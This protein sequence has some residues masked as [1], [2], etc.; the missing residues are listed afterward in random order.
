MTR[1]GITFNK[2]HY[3]H[4]SLLNGYPCPENPLRIKNIMEYLENSGLIDGDQF[5]FYDAFQASMMDI[6]RVHTREY[7]E[8]IKA[9]TMD[10]RQSPGKDVYVCPS[11]FDVI[12]QALGC[13]LKAGELV[14]TGE[15]KH[16]YAIIRPPG[17]HAGPESCN[18][19]CLFNN[20]GILARYLLEVKGL[21]RI[22]I[23]NIDAHASDGTYAAFEA[24]PQVLC[25]S[26]HQDQKTLYPFKGFIKDIGV[27]PALGYCINM[28][29]PTESGN[30]E[31]S[32]FYD[33]VAEKVLDRFNPQL[34]ILE[35]GFDAYH[36]EPL[37]KLNLT[38]DGYYRIIFKLASKWSVVTLLEGGYH[39]D[40][41]LLASVVLR[42][43]AGIENIEDEVD[44][45]DLL[46][47][48]HAK[49]R[50]EFNNNLSHLKTRLEPY[51][52]PW[53]RS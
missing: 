12:L 19:F 30:P 4:D 7:V 20:S 44:Q 25:I 48:R 49:T 46:A 10:P 18:G 32:L 9:C 35:C 42:A 5:R 16:S 17:H 36:K 13:I 15:C 45:I 1:V 22:A 11:S 34:I 14:I 50:K 8:L 33:E 53:D 29:M 28:E 47:S 21:E 27:R 51:W 3:L 52:G 39:D 38:V 23:V 31:Y 37:A 26:I 41:G 6:L 40:L 2:N 24:D 43:L